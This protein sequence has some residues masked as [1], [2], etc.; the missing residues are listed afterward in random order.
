MSA[1]ASTA[2]TVRVAAVQMVST[3]RG[4]TA[5]LAAAE[6]LIAEAAATGAQL[7]A[8]PEYFCLMGMK[9]T[10]KVAVREPLGRGPIQEFLAAQARQARHLAGRWNTAARSA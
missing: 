3:P 2:R 9:D 7:I 4:S 1:E 8:L 10:D 5:N 6:A